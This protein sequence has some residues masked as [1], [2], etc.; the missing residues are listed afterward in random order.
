MSGNLPI[1]PFLENDTSMLSRKFGKEVVNYYAGGSLN[2]YSFLR[3]DTSFLRKAIIS[4]RARFIA[5]DKL[6]PLSLDKTQLAYLS[7]NDV[8]PVLG[9]ASEE[10]FRLTEEEIIAKYDSSAAAPL[11]VFLGL[12]EG[13][14]GQEEIATAEHGPVKGDAY[15]AVDITAKGVNAEAAA[16]F[17]K[18][19]AEQGKVIQT[20]P[21]GMSLDAE[22][23]KFSRAPPFS[24]PSTRMLN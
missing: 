18:Q 15:F 11:I 24:S 23:G 4:P 13:G 7:F 6:N 21:R 17:V 1:L 2:R 3:P 22:A 16:A 5:L 19:Q 9:A 12:L 8:K 20:N 14:V 10:L